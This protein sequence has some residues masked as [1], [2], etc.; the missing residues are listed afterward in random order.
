MRFG[1]AWRMA[2]LASLALLVS[3]QLCMLTTCLPRLIH[4]R[5]GAAHAC[6]RAGGPGAAATAGA[7][8]PEPE[9]AMPCNM[10]LTSVTAP[11]LSVVAP[12]TPPF[13]LFAA[14]VLL[15]PPAGVS[16]PVAAD[17]T[18][19]PPSRTLPATAGLRAPPAA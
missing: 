1:T 16:M 2:V 14:V 17:D 8:L 19:P 3:G 4:H 5:A 13:A 15:L 18:G 6:C 10:A 7:E 11:E 12:A 9:G